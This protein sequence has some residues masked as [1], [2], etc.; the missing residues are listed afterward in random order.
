MLL[1]VL[2]GILVK[3]I[4]FVKWKKTTLF[5]IIIAVLCN[6]ISCGK[7]DKYL[8]YDRKDDAYRI[9]RLAIDNNVDVE[10]MKKELI[11]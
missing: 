9:I 2:W 5:F 1:F 6:L 8:E 3:N 11:K 10:N 4:I 7:K